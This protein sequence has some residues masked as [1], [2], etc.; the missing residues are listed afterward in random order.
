MEAVS[1]D[2]KATVRCGFF[3]GNIAD[4]GNML[5]KINFL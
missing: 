4:S 1:P 5:Q 3:I 2:K